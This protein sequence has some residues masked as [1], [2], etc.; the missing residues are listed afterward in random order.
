MHL[1]PQCSY[2]EMGCGHRR[3]VSLGQS[4]QLAW[5]GQCRSR[6]KERPC[7]KHSGR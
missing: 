6:T 4:D 3:L 5:S 2:R 7:L 1:S